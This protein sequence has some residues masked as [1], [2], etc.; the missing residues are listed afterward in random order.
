MSYK[1]DYD[2]DSCKLIIFMLMMDMFIA[3]Y[4]LF[5]QIDRTIAIEMAVVEDGTMINVLR[6]P[7]HMLVA[8]MVVITTTTIATMVIPAE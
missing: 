3:F 1:R 2:S 5:W 8:N 7:P 6:L 4:C